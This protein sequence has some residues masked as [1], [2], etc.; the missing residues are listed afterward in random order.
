MR[1]CSVMNIIMTC[2]LFSLPWNTRCS[3]VA[4]PALFILQC[5]CLFT[6][7]RFCSFYLVQFLTPEVCSWRCLKSTVCRWVWARFLIETRDL[8]ENACFL[9]LL[10][11]GYVLFL[12]REATSL[13]S[14]SCPVAVSFIYLLLS[15]ASKQQRRQSSVRFWRHRKSQVE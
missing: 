5:D 7:G 6:F 2:T 11:A 10:K 8:C 14:N 13:T 12:A 15:P 4:S 3:S 9:F 1:F